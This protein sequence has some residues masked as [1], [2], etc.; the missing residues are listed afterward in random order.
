M[1]TNDPSPLVGVIMGSKS[2][3][4]TMRHADQVLTDFEVPH[5]SSGQLGAPHARRDRRVGPAGRGAR[6]QSHHRGG[7]RRRAP[8]GRGGGIHDRAR[9]W[10]ADREPGAQGPRLAAVDGAD[11]GRHPRGHA[12][13]WQG[14]ARPTRRCWPS[15]FSP[16]PTRRCATRSRRSARCRPRGSS[17]RSCPEL[18]PPAWPPITFTIVSLKGI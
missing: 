15:R 18:A 2:D 13:H 6:H 10:R 4:E 8:G 12:R 7:R 14:R 5:E 17:K 16:P 9:A 3:W 11:A 1:A